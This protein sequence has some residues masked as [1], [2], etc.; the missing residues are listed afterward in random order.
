M[1]SL[2]DGCPVDHYL[3][4][5]IAKRDMKCDERS[6]T[7]LAR[8][9]VSSL[10]PVETNMYRNPMEGNIGVGATESLEMIVNGGNEEDIICK[11]RV[12]WRVE[13]KGSLRRCRWKLVEDCRHIVVVVVVQ[14]LAIGLANLEIRVRIPISAGHFSLV[15]PPSGQKSLKCCHNTI[16]NRICICICI[17]DSDSC[18][19]KE[20]KKPARTPGRRQTIIREPPSCLPA[21][22]VHD[23]EKKKIRSAISSVWKVL[24]LFESRKERVIVPHTKA[25]PV[26]PSLLADPPVK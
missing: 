2:S 11:S 26:V 15:L 3:N 19:Y 1:C 12:E 17:E 18:H 9:C 6:L 24:V 10:I 4:A 5:G 13:Q 23:I 21:P 16:L 25:A 22:Q 7:S 20:S 8:C 14:W